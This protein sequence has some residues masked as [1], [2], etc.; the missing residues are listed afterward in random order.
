MKPSRKPLTSRRLLSA[1]EVE[2]VDVIEDV[3][4]SWFS[5]SDA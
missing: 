2:R 4:M 3:G 5:Y 1:T